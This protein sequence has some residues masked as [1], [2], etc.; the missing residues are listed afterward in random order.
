[1]DPNFFQFDPNLQNSQNTQDLQDLQN[2]NL[3]NDNRLFPMINQIIDSRS[4]NCDSISL[5]EQ[6]L[7]MFNIYLNFYFILG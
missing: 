7:R 2:I 5:I 6:Q 3:I 1:M 4:N